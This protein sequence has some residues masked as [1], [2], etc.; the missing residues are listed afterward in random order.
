MDRSIVYTY[1]HVL[2]WFYIQPQRKIRQPHSNWL[3]SHH[4]VTMHCKDPSPRARYGLYVPVE[5]IRLANSNQIGNVRSTFTWPLNHNLWWKGWEKTNLFWKLWWSPIFY[6]YRLT[7]LMISRHVKNM[8]P[9]RSKPSDIRSNL[10]FWLSKK[11]KRNDKLSL[12]SVLMVWTTSRIGPVSIL[13]YCQGDTGKLNLF[14]STGFHSIEP[15]HRL[16]SKDL[17]GYIAINGIPSDIPLYLSSVPARTENL[18][19]Q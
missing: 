1:I 13:D 3:H 11:W 2:P 14:Q 16:Q 5:L 15:D 4:F 19:Y 12:V 8:L 6:T 9:A 7:P 18:T 10:A 17:A